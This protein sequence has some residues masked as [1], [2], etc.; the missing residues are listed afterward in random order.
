MNFEII[1]IFLIKLFF[2]QD[3]NVKAKNQNEKR[4]F[5]KQK[6][7]FITFKELSLN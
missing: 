3:Q 7:F 1:L 2:L 5:M 4:D 6:V